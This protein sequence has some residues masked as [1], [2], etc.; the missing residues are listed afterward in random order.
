MQE[1]R[2]GCFFLNAVYVVLHSDHLKP[3]Y[4]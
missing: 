1:N 2:S 3:S 4:R